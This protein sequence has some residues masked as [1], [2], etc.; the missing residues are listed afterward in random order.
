MNRF[1]IILLAF[2][3][4]SA[5]NAEQVTKQAALQKAKQF[6]PDKNFTVAKSRSLARGVDP[7]TEEADF[8]ILNADNGGYVIVS[9]DDRT[10][11][12]LGYSEQGNLDIEKAPDNLK[13]WLDEYARQIEAIKSLPQRTTR[14]TSSLPNSWPA[15][16]PLLSAK[17]G[18]DGPFNYMCPDANGKDFD[19]EGYDSN[20]RCPTGCVAT[21]LAQVMYYWKWP[22]N[23]Q[24]LDGYSIGHYVNGI[25][26]VEDKK[27]KGL[28]ATSFNWEKM[29]DEYVYSE[30]GEAADAVAELMRY[31]GQASSM[32]YDYGLVGSCT[33]ISGIH[34]SQIGYSKNV[35]YVMRGDYAAT[36]WEAL[37]YE[38]LAAKHPIL[39]GG[40]NKYIG[41][42][43][44]VDGYD[45]KGLFHINFGWNG[46]SDDYYA[47]AIYETDQ[48]EESP[49]L[50]K[51]EHTD[52]PFSQEAVL[53]LKPVE[54]D[55]KV[56][57]NIH[58]SLGSFL[59]K[60][61]TRVNGSVDFTSVVLPFD[62][63]A[64]YNTCPE[65]D[66]NIE[67]GW[68]LYRDNQF[69]KCIGS[70]KDVNG[71]YVGAA[72]ALVRFLSD[73]DL[74]ADFGSGLETGQYQLY[75]VYRFQN[76]EDWTRCSGLGNS[77]IADITST[78][79][80]LRRTD[81]GGR[82]FTVNSFSYSE[83]SVDNPITVKANVTNYGDWDLLL[84]NL[85]IQKQGSDTWINVA[86][87]GKY[88]YKDNTGDVEMSFTLQE[89]GTYNLKVTSCSS[90]E[91]LKTAT[92][93]VEANVDIVIDHVKYRCSPA[94]GTAII[95]KNEDNYN[96]YGNGKSDI[97]S[98][99]ILPT[100]VAN[101][102]ECKVKTI[103]EHALEK[104]GIVC[105]L[106]IP[107]G[108]ESIRYCA[109]EHWYSLEHL[110]IPSTVKEIGQ[111]AFG[112][113]HKLKTV[114]SYMRE[115]PF[116]YPDVFKTGEYDS[117]TN[118]Y[119]DYFPAATLYVPAGCAKK[120]GDA[121]TWKLFTNIVEMPSTVK[122]DADG[123]GDVTLKDVEL[124]KEYIMTGKTEGLI[125]TNADINGDEKLNVI[126]IVYI[127][128]IIKN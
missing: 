21:A 42:A 59:T 39:Y 100:V 82:Y 37:I 88:I 64:W 91:A 61:Y 105:E 93:T 65:S 111:Y 47:L 128:N 23:C 56:L 74:T 52:Y 28:P 24:A 14:T 76:N 122:G 36:Q 96:E 25:E 10:R 110:T 70:K 30:T 7:Q 66:F 19:E 121:Y 51:G 79:L 31:C 9:G 125:F 46:A 115:P 15:I 40:S 89:P 98:I 94:Y 50:I 18:Q 71:L 103:D 16:S 92:M 77:L 13:W 3:V 69:I 38:E 8:Y 107:E 90:D 1:F 53:G 20:N 95:V 41:H 68:G 27:V 55:E 43:F 11:E 44:V 114:T 17:W 54:P 112:Y 109:F 113:T 108:I 116:I 104:L 118:T 126:D 26:F 72:P 106:V 86:Q 67:V 4:T 58:S 29:K 35:D 34:Y 33:H 62:L 57:P 49:E 123:D 85:W 119:H 12:I 127:L 99:T 78:T 80:I 102:V 32:N 87:G 6:M 48:L 63:Y 124:V 84:L 101:G 73:V 2:M 22:K 120:Y 83:L 97:T 75:Q 5:M 117:S 81:I 45:G 60:E